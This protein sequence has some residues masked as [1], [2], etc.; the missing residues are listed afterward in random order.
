MLFCYLFV[1]IARQNAKRKSQEKVEE[2][3]EDEDSDE[4]SSSSETEDSEEE[5]TEEAEEET[6]TLPIICHAKSPPK[7]L[8][9]VFQI[10]F[11]LLLY[12]LCSSYFNSSW[13]FS[14]LL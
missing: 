5:E 2:G 14:K 8:V 12:F 9:R 6:G 7:R 13:K 1:L 3:S 11:E 4:A 10:E